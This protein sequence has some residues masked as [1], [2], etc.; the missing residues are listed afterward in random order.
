MARVQPLQRR[1]RIGLAGLVGIALLGSLRTASRAAADERAAPRA[2][3]AAGACACAPLAAGATVAEAHANPHNAYNARHW[4]HVAEFFLPARS[5]LRRDG[6]VDGGLAARGNASAD[7]V[8]VLA[9]PSW[10]RQLTPM[11]RL[12]L[13]AALTDARAARRVHFV[14]AAAA[15]AAEPC[16][17]APAPAARLSL[18]H[19]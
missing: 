3:A 7:A 14:G 17:G 13:A 4:F 8:V 16:G 5:A 9:A 18:I 19:I 11:T 10:A 15:S 1:F 6:R 12:L 2:A